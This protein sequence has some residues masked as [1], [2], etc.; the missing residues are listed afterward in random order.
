MA[1][2]AI[3]SNRPKSLK[4]SQDA[5]SNLDAA[6]DAASKSKG[7]KKDDKKDPTQSK[8]EGEKKTSILTNTSDPSPTD[9]TA[10]PDSPKVTKLRKKKM[11]SDASDTNEQESANSSEEGDSGH[12][13]EEKSRPD[14]R[15]V[16]E[17]SM[18]PSSSAPPY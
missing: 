2:S 10:K 18:R 9:T 8:D 15:N 1:T 13:R 14:D 12:Y 3:K 17:W 7:E 4:N 5:A 6:K 16:V 11:G